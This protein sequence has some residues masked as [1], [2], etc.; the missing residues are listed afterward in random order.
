M[1]VSFAC[2]VAEGVAVGCWQ[3][4]ALAAA[5]PICPQRGP[6][7][8]SVPLSTGLLGIPARHVR[9]HGDLVSGRQLGVGA[10]A[11]VS[12]VTFGGGR[13]AIKVSLRRFTLLHKPLPSPFPD[14]LSQ[15]PQPHS[16]AR[17][18]STCSRS[19]TCTALSQGLRSTCTLWGKWRPKP[20]CCVHPHANTRTS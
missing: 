6:D 5:L 12:E 7:A 20:Q 8:S 15:P 10:M 1:R 19:Q 9:W 17:R 16:H 11:R 3:L 4:V 13:L 2:G 18:N 14:P